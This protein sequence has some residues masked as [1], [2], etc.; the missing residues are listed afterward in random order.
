MTGTAGMFKDRT[1]VPEK[2]LSAW[3]GQRFGKGKKYGRKLFKK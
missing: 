1:A 2:S 3:A